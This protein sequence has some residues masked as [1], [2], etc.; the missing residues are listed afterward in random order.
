MPG[1]DRLE[2]ERVRFCEETGSLARVIPGVLDQG[3]GAE[4][5]TGDPQT[6]GFGELAGL[7]RCAAVVVAPELELGVAG[8]PQHFKRAR[9]VELV[10]SQQVTDRED[11][12]ADAIERDIA[13]LAKAV[14]PTALA[15]PAAVAI[16]GPRETRNRPER[17]HRRRAAGGT[18][19]AAA[20]QRAPVDH[21]GLL[22]P[23]TGD[24]AGIPRPLEPRLPRRRRRSTRNARHVSE[25][26][27]VLGAVQAQVGRRLDPVQRATREWAPRARSSMTR[28]A[29][30]A[31]ARVHRS[32]AAA[33]RLSRPSLLPAAGGVVDRHRYAAMH[34]FDPVCELA[35]VGVVNESSTVGRVDT[36]AA[37]LAGPNSAY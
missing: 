35:A 16:M 15:T 10:V 22:L 17:P 11:L 24:C 34:R 5:V 27:A 31:E 32:P 9:H 21:G 36:S 37:W 33:T 20:S 23:P 12:D 14:V 18:N 25:A 30:L 8:V 29:P 13:A 26:T 28:R 6:V 19:E 1:A 4:V 2:P 7:R 3:A